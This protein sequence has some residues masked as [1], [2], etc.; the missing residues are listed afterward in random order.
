MSRLNAVLRQIDDGLEAAMKRWFDLLRIPSISAVPAHAG[1]CRAAAAFMADLLNAI[2]VAAEV[3]ETAG[4]PMVVGHVAGRD[5]SRRVLFYGHYD[6]QP[7]DPL[8]EWKTDPFAPALVTGD[9]GRA[10]VYA[11]GAADD[12][13]QLLTFIEALA[14]H[15]AVHGRPPVDVVILLEGEEESGSPS[16]E[17]FLRANAD[18]LRADM[19]LICDTNQWDADTPAITTRLRGLV[20]DEVTIKAAKA[21]LHSGLFGGPAHNPLHIISHIIADLWDDDGRVSL[22]GFYD[23]V[24]ELPEALRTQWAALDMTDEKVM[25]QMG[26]QP[27]PAGERGY[28]ALELNWARPTAEING[29]GGGYQGPGAKTVIPAEAFFKISFRLVGKQDPLKVRAAFRDHVRARLPSGVTASFADDDG[30]A[31]AAIEV[32]EN[33]PLVR[34]AARALTDEWGK[35]PVM[36]GCGASIPVVASFRDIL[37]MDS[38]LMGFGLA[39]DAIHS[40][41]EKYDVACFHKGMRSWAR[42]LDALT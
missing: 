26:M 28:S 5:R 9:D 40:P 22:P 11:R 36:M 17:P 35:E 32:D 42:L 14:A 20:H 15:M 33:A 16:L 8:D 19:A 34:L 13:G 3:R 30:G 38:L 37:G 10:R 41:N 31:S 1:D 25:A 7:V 18:E 21:D 12:K 6:V 29:I 23:G 39:D 4:L 27:P 24:P 2:G